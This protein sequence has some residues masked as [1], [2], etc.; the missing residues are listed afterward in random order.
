MSINNNELV[1]WQRD[2]LDFIK[3]ESCVV[4]SAP[5]GSGKTRC[6]E[7]WA[8]NK[9]ERPIFIT[10]PI[11][12]LSN[13]KF[14][15]L[16][17]RGY[18]VGLETGDICYF[19]DGDCDIICCTQEIYNYKYRDYENSTLIID[20]FSYVYDATD[21]A[22]AYVDSLVYSKATNIF[23]CSA[24]LGNP[25][26]VM[27]YVNRISKRSFCLYESE[28][29]LTEL[30]YKGEIPMWK[31]HNSFV[32]AYSK[33]ECYRLTRLLYDKR[34]MNISSIGTN[35]DPRNRYRG[36]IKELAAK[37]KITNSELI[38][39]TLMGVAYYCG[40][41]LPKE[42]L[43][44][45]ELLEC[46]YVD[47]VVGTDA[48]ALGVNFP[49]ENVVFSGLS[50]NTSCKSP[51]GTGKIISKNLFEQLSGRAGRKSYYDKGYVY[52]CSD[53]YGQ[54]LEM[55]FWQLVRAPKEPFRIQVGSN[56]RDI[57]NGNLTIEDDV[58]WR[59]VLS[60]VHLDYEKILKDTQEEINFIRNLNVCEYYF[61]K[62]YN[63]D[64]SVGLET[65]IGDKSKK[66][67]D[68]FRN[69][70]RQL[71][72]IQ[73]LFQEY[74]GKVYMN[75]YPSERNCS[76][77]IDI[78]LGVPMERLL[79][80]YCYFGKNKDYDIKALLDF[81]KYM[82]RLPEKYLQIYNLAELDNLINVIDPTVLNPH[83]CGLSKKSS[84]KVNKPKPKYKYKRKTDEFKCPFRFEIVKYNGRM[85]IKIL[86]ESD[87]ILLCDY[88]K[89]G[90]EKLNL[91]Y[92]PLRSIY[93]LVGYISCDEMRILWG[94][95][96]F[97]SLG[98]TLDDF[99]YDNSL[100]FESFYSRVLSKK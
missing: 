8:F 39:F 9:K 68:A 23:I 32:V 62:Y 95:V 34:M 44:I 71:E 17:E 48:L 51:R 33:K 22:R 65:V 84:N 49:I 31:I 20:E 5:T 7:E 41:L 15:S 74:I 6:Y 67:Q 98:N 97:D 70:F 55:N 54:P 58:N 10:A 81:R 96:N 27:K 73:S 88:Q 14:R 72:S 13:Q 59:I 42:K 61:S 93:N 2:C 26:D 24:T 4:L 76:L 46:G 100:S 75:E 86:Q 29:R 57:L 83:S 66:E 19:P 94:R 64:I 78:L 21:R 77:L 37:Y 87:K 40:K 53:F 36:I 91:T 11:K 25:D 45:E 3:D 79:K 89:Y 52:C 99:C 35:S 80:I 38:E 82:R 16:K 18:K 30:E 69:K 28:D 43:F 90:N 60:T 85:Y 56:I 12:A 92:I 1:E 50:K 47:T 63:L